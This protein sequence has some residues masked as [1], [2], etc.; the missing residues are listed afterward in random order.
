MNSIKNGPL[1]HADTFAYPPPRGAWTYP[2]DRCNS[3]DSAPRMG[4]S[5]GGLVELESVPCPDRAAYLILTPGCV[6]GFLPKECDR[7]A[8]QHEA[9]IDAAWRYAPG[10]WRTMPNQPVDDTHEEPTP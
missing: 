8:R 9:N 1:A 6:P 7:H 3:S 10:Q 2:D 5:R 4:A